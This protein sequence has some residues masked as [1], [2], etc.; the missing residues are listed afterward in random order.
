MSFSERLYEYVKLV[1]AWEHI[2]D[3]ASLEAEKLAVERADLSEELIRYVIGLENRV[4]SLLEYCYEETI[5]GVYV[6]TSC[7]A[8]KHTKHGDWC[9]VGNE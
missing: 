9:A 6:C 1:K 5:D 4:N 3:R 2:E 7:G 8:K